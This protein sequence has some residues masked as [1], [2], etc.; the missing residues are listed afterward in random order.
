[1]GSVG[2]REPSGLPRGIG[3]ALVAL[4]VG[5]AVTVGILVFLN[6]SAE[7]APGCPSA[8]AFYNVNKIA[9][10]SL[11]CASVRGELCYSAEISSLI[12]GLR[13]SDL[14]FKVIGDPSG[15]NVLNGTPISLGPAAR[16][17]LL[18]NSPVNLAVWNWTTATSV[19]GGGEHVSTTATVTAILD[20]GLVATSLGS[21][22]WWAFYS[23][24][25]QGGGVPV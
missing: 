12:D 18:Q 19:S 3:V 20:T 5:A 13:V 15:S 25:D 16:V 17:T 7:C 22:Y 6:P 9:P 24:S 8:F 21:A 2:R 14:S 10:G 23:S 1:M 4:T 11:G